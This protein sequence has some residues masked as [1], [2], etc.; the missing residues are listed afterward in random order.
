MEWAG[1]PIQYI[2][3]ICKPLSNAGFVV[4]YSYQ[5]MDNK[6]YYEVLNLEIVKH[7]QTIVGYEMNGEK[8]DIGPG[9]SLRLKV[10]TQIGY[11]MAKCIKA[12][13]FV[14]DYKYIDMGHGG[15]REDH[16]YYSPR[17]GIQLF[18]LSIFFFS[19]TIYCN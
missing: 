3:E 13:E 1:V 16:R 14:E 10:E 7:P 5:Y 11:K 15:H 17:D 4:F 12:L 9:A 2:I 6:Q 18:F 8:L 19:M